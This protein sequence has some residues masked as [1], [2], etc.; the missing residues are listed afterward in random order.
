MCI[1]RRPF[2]TLCGHIQSHLESVCGKSF[3]RCASHVLSFK[4]LEH[5]SATVFFPGCSRRCL[6]AS[7]AWSRNAWHVVLKRLRSQHVSHRL[8]RREVDSF[9][10]C[11][12]EGSSTPSSVRHRRTVSTCA[13]DTAVAV[14]SSS[15]SYFLMCRPLVVNDALFADL[16]WIFSGRSVLLI[17]SRLT[18]E[19][20]LSVSKMFSITRSGATPKADVRVKIQRPTP[21]AMVLYPSHVEVSHFGGYSMPQ[22]HATPVDEGFH[23]RTVSM[24]V[25]F[26]PT[27]VVSKLQRRC[28][29]RGACGRM[30]GVG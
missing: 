29:S 2:D 5:S 15:K 8:V 30:R 13:C 17:S 20:W 9:R 12:G 3:R 7:V 22:T 18:L 24:L 11:V 26:T 1:P 25:L 27:F 16:S 21:Q 19:S 6:L 23:M 14:L 10:N 28:L 4:T